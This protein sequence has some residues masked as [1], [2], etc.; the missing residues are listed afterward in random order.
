ME[1]ICVNLS[2]SPT[3]GIDMGVE[4]GGLRCMVPDQQYGMLLLTSPWN[5]V[6]HGGSLVPTIFLAIYTVYHFRV[7]MLLL[8]VYHLLIFYLYF[9]YSR[10]RHKW[11]FVVIPWRS[12]LFLFQI[13]HCRSLF[14]KYVVNVS[15]PTVKISMLTETDRFNYTYQRK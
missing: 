6:V 15:S 4:G 2:I 9:N 10:Y 11:V 5:R 1:T 3:N 14:I 8:C 12:N 13:L 7:D